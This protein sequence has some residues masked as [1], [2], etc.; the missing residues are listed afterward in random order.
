MKDQWAVLKDKSVVLFKRGREKLG[1]LKHNVKE[2]LD[3]YNEL[4]K[5]DLALAGEK[6]D[7]MKDRAKGQLEVAKEVVGGKLKG[8]QKVAGEKLEN[9]QSAAMKLE[10]VAKSVIEKMQSVLSTKTQTPVGPSAHELF[11]ELVAESKKLRNAETFEEF[12][13]VINKKGHFQQAERS[14]GL[15]SRQGTSANAKHTLETI[16]HV[17]QEGAKGGWLTNDDLNA[18]AAMKPHLEK[19]MEAALNHNPDLRLE[20]EQAF[21]DVE[22]NVIYGPVIQGTEEMLAHFDQNQAILFKVFDFVKPENG[23]FLIE[24]EVYSEKTIQGS[25]DE[26]RKSKEAYN[27]YLENKDKA[28]FRSNVANPKFSR[29]LKTGIFE[30]LKAGIK[31]MDPDYK[32]SDHELSAEFREIEQM[33]K[34]NAGKEGVPL[35]WNKLNQF[36]AKFGAAVDQFNP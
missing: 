14:L 25:A 11:K 30:L 3:Q 16:I 5:K 9:L 10:S 20:L 1:E 15:E 29:V 2:G 34:A 31:K 36:I 27:K 17:L 8:I 24:G 4:G 28:A 23:K 18:L 13:L 19:Q 6:I 35:D 33:F 7:S 22:V 26:L 32:T 12:K 21:N